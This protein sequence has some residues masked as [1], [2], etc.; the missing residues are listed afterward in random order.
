LGHFSSWPTAEISGGLVALFRQLELERI[1]AKLLEV[2]VK[3]G[4]LWP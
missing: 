3:F 1:E 4:T 2:S